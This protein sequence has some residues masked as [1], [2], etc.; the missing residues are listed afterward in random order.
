MREFLVKVGKTKDVKINYAQR[1]VTV[2][3]EQHSWKTVG[4]VEQTGLCGCEFHDI[5]GFYPAHWTRWL[6]TRIRRYSA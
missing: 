1:M 2:G 4:Y 3:N 6:R 5:V